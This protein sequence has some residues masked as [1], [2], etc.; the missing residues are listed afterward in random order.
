M[1]DQAAIIP[2]E[3][4][5]EP[6]TSASGIMTFLESP[7][8]FHWFKILKKRESTKAME[9]GTQ[10]H[11]LV[12]EPEKFYQSYFT[13]LAL[14]EGFRILKTVDDMKQF[15]TDSGHKPFKGKKEDLA[16]QCAQL[17]L[18]EPSQTLIYDEWVEDQTRNKQYISPES[19]ERLHGMAESIRSHAFAKRYLQFAKKE[20]PFEEELFGI[21]MRGRIDWLVDEPSLPWV[22]VIDVKKTKSAKWFKF[23]YIIRDMN[24]HVQAAIYSAWAEK[25]YQKPVLYVWMAVEPAAPF[26]CEAH[27][28][29]DAVLEV[30]ATKAKWAVRN[31]LECLKTNIWNGYTDGEVHNVGLPKDEFDLAAGMELENEDAEC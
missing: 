5:A 22:I 13:D 25:K 10:I 21:K 28:T 20:V 18:N 7:K 12:L 27:S 11:M 30:G 3:A 26:I 17:M 19:W 8:H 31:L 15:I 24:L 23:Q 29:S 1:S 9:E 4:Q 16:F 6:Q 14:P 2:T